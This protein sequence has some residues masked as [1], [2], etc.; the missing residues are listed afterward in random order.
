M[1]EEDE[2]MRISSKKPVQNA[3]LVFMLVGTVVLLAGCVKTQIL[4][5]SVLHEQLI[6]GV[7][8]GSA[9]GGPNSA[10]VKVTIEGQKIVKIDIIKHS[11]MKG[12]KAEPILPQRIID[13]QSTAV[14]AVSGATNSSKVI[15][16]AVQ[17][18]IEQA[19]QAK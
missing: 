15:M 16:N 7:Y 12:K 19:Y 4:G 2:S 13:A 6:D 10:V 3:I 8:E 5:G 14:D 11:A 1:I 17:N 9:K 18:A